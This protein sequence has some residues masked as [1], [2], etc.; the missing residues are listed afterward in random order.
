MRV[1]KW[2]KEGLAPI[3]GIREGHCVAMTC[4]QEAEDV[5]AR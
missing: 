1:S 5:K 2:Q 3:L 4:E